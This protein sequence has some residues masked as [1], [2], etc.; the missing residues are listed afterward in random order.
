M[1]DN[2]ISPE[3]R[4]VINTYG[5]FAYEKY[6]KKTTIALAP[7]HNKKVN[8]AE[9]AIQTVKDHLISNV[10]GVDKNFPLKA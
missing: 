1:M 3:V 5:E 10:A 4:A 2:E 8:N 7:P 9:R 6:Q